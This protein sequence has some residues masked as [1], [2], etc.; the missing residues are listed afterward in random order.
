MGFHSLPVD[1]DPANPDWQQIEDALDH[2]AEAARS[3][4][5]ADAFYRVLLERMVL[6]SGASSSAVWTASRTGELR[7]ALQIDAG[8]VPTVAIARRRQLVEQVLQSGELCRA[9]VDEVCVALEPFR[10]DSRVIGAI[11]LSHVGLTSPAQ[12]AGQIRILAAMVELTEEYHR[13]RELSHLRQSEQARADFDRFALGIHRSLVAGETAFAIANDGRRIVA[14]DRASVLVRHGQKY[15]VAATSGVDVLDRRA[16]QVRALETLANRA[17]AVGD[18]LWYSDGGADLPDEVERPLQGYLDESHARVLAIVPLYAAPPP[19]ESPG[20]PI[21]ALVAEQFQTSPHDD[22]LRDRLTAVAAHAGVALGNALVHTRQP[23]ARTGRALAKL[24]WLTEA[25]QLPKTSLVAAGIAA[26]VAALALIP[27]DFDIEAKGELQPKVRREVF[28]SDDGVV[29]E[30]LAEHG[31]KVTADEPLVVLRKPELDLELRR[32]AG[33]IQTAQK[34]LAAVQA[35]RLSNT[36]TS[37]DDRRDAHQRT[38][39]E[40]ELKEQL[41]GL[42]VERD[43]L[44]EQREALVVRSPI[45]GEAITWNVE[46]LLAARPV[47]RGQ[48]LLT[49]ADLSGPWVVELHVPDDRTGHVLEARST[50]QQPLAVSFALSAEPGVEYQGTLNDL[51][52][53]TDVDDVAGPTVLATVSFD[54]KQVSG[55]RP[56][57]TV[58]ARIH[59]GQRS[60]GYVWLHDLYEFVQTHWWW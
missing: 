34:K 55:L 56:G 59:C 10:S 19:D 42:Q 54:R 2:L 37:P 45:A 46:E 12:Q 60:L 27:A 25:R 41:N 7:L 48:A 49:V 22:Q 47:E 13:H 30:L 16:K 36:R 44:T 52:L 5:S 11:E 39:D 20:Q 6:A 51:A 33:E 8:R 58:L 14:C 1:S 18:P 43:L 17:M 21:G 50:A 35:E 15:R 32:V 3:S 24:R 4:P 53:A 31:R 29:S 28:A 57:A 40:E 23:L 26:I 9:N 38:A